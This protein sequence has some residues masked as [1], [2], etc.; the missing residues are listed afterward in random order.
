M[1]TYNKDVAVTL[2]DRTIGELAI[3][4]R[5]PTLIDMKIAY[6]NSAIPVFWLKTQITELFASMELPTGVD[7]ERIEECARNIYHS[8]YSLNL[9]E[10]LL[11]FAKCK[12]AHF[13]KFY[14]TSGPNQLMDMFNSFMTERNKSIAVAES[15]MTLQR[16]EERQSKNEYQEY[17]ELKKRAQNGDMSAKKE[18]NNLLIQ[19]RNE[20]R[21][22]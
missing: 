13:G 14:G 10:L 7:N 3:D 5:I 16:I 9:L 18:L 17:Q 12:M 19:F 2:L 15:K 21:N 6:N 1:A 22:I 20:K 11:F 8:H 4:T